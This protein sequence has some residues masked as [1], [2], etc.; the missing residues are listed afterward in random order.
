VSLNTASL[1]E[2]NALQGGGLIARAIIRGRPYTSVEELL[3]KQVLNRSTYKR[4]AHQVA[5]R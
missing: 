4:I 1:E 2:L 5:V 3:V